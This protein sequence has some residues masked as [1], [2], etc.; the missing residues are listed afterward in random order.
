MQAPRFHDFAFGISLSSE[1]SILDDVSPLGPF[2]PSLSFF[3]A[4]SSS[5]S[6]PFVLRTEECSAFEFIHRSN[7]M[8]KLP[9]IT[10]GIYYRG[11]DRRD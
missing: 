1:A 2:H 11:I 8:F 6:H 3:L 10:P 9:T 5:R 7:L 4:S